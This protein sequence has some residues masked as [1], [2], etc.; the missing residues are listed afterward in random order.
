MHDGLLATKLNSPHV[1]P[2]LIARPDLAERL[3]DATTYDLCLVCSPPGFGKTTLLAAWAAASHRPVAWLSLDADDDD[4]TRFWRYALAALDQALPGSGRRAAAL[5]TRPGDVSTAGLVTALI[6]DLAAHDEPVVLVLDDYHVIGSREIHDGV[7]FLLGHLPPGLRLVIAGRADPPLPL[8]DLRAHAQL[9]E[10]RTADLRFTA[11]EA[12][13]FLGD[14]WGLTLPQ[15]AVDALAERTEGWVAGLQL[16]A[17]SLRHQPDPSAFVASFAGSHRFVLDYLSEEVL[18]RQPAEMRD[19]LLT[20][21]VLEQLSGPLCDAVTGRSDGQ[22]ML[23]AAERANLF[24]VPLD[25]HRHWYRYHHLFADLLRARLGQDCPERVAELHHRAIGW[26]RANGL[27]TGAVHHALAAGDTNAAIRLIEATAEELIW[28]RSEGATLERWL[29]A[30]PAGT[31]SRRPRLA[32]ARALRALAGARMEEVAASIAAAERAP[33]SARAEPFEPTVGRHESELVNIEATITFIRAVLA[34]RCGD[35]EGADVYARQ[36]LGQM[37]AD[38]RQ[39]RLVAH[40]MP[41][42]AAWTAGRLSEAERLADASIVDLQIDDRPVLATRLLYDKGQVQMASG[43]LCAAEQTYRRAY[44]WMAPPGV[45]PMPAASLQLLG[46]AEVLRQRN[47]LEAALELATHGLELSRLLWSTEPTAAGLA[48]LA[49]IQYALGDQAA[50]RATADEA[51]R[52]IPSAAIVSLFNPG[53]AERARLLLALGDVDEAAA[54]VAERGLRD[55]DVPVYPREREYLVLVRLLLAREA[56]DR[57]LSLLDRLHADAETS[58]RIGSVIEI[59]LLQALAF[60][61][62]ADSPRALDTLADALALAQPEGYVRVFS[63]EGPRLAG[64]LRRLV[65]P[66]RR[67]NGSTVVDVHYVARLLNAVS[68]EP[69]ALPSPVVRGAGRAILV[70]PLTERESEVLNLVAE[71]RSNLEIAERLVVTLDT[72][73]RHMTHILG[74]LGAVSRTHAVARARELRLLN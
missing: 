11:T 8:A 12:A 10:L 15:D 4:P 28:W 41:T 21:S 40:A 39:L 50:A 73:K 55:A 1:R 45:T 51:A 17:L 30:L 47:D 9:A 38:D 67:G 2:G 36:A 66:G 52:T 48:T 32:L 64:L 56:P 35:A 29:A 68:P 7:A 60:D 58:G 62:A 70:E 5:L 6:N 65:A 18:A 57:A 44:A 31:L 46:L 33:A 37:A 16:A 19:F 74:K 69:A 49:W 3:D 14:L 59:R 42:E 61:V 72:V 26:Y 25:E 53:P 34:T 54:W 71:G 63:D 27:V 22:Q 23:E 24:V 43:R 20:T 13:A